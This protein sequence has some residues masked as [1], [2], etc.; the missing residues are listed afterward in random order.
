MNVQQLI[1]ELQNHP[2]DLRV[3]R[4]GYEGGFDD[5]SN[6]ELMEIIVDYNDGHSWWNGKHVHPSQTLPPTPTGDEQ[7]LLI[8]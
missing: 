6:A 3:I 2:P 4:K 1:E 5:V 8:H 7:A